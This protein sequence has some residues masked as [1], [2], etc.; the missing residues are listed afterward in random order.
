M[1]QQWC[2]VTIVTI[3]H[4]WFVKSLLNKNII[5]NKS[6]ILMNSLSPLKNTSHLKEWTCLNLLYTIFILHS[7]AVKRSDWFF[8]ARWSMDNRDDYYQSGVCQWGCLYY[9]PIVAGRQTGGSS[10]RR[11]SH[12]HISLKKLDWLVGFGILDFFFK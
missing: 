4:F 6:T 8:F 1:H 10:I 12:L 3:S 2:M 9:I 7:G 11:C 5:Y